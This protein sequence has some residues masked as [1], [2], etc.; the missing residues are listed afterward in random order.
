MAIREFARS[1]RTGPLNA[2]SNANAALPERMLMTF[3]AANSARR[4]QKSSCSEATP[5]QRPWSARQA[6]QILR[7]S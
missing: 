3:E 6:T 1:M 2:G 5:M 4:A 7:G